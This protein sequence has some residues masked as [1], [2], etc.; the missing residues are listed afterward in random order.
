[1]LTSIRAI[2]QV[3]TEGTLSFSEPL[4]LS[5]LNSGGICPSSRLMGGV[6]RRRAEALNLFEVSEV[7]L[8]SVERISASPWKRSILSGEFFE[9]V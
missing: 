9:A 6:R 3:R 8:F 1:M 2:G 4:P 5:M 7:L